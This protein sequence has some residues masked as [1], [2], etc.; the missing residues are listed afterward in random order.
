MT[1][2]GKPIK[3]HEDVPETTEMPRKEPVPPVPQK[4]E[5]PEK[6]PVPVP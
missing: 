6:K 4:K 2:I 3:I 1:G 5:T